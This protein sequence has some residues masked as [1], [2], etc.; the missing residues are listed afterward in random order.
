MVRYARALRLVVSGHTHQALEFG[1]DGVRHV[2]VPSSG[3]VI[4]DS[5]RVP[6]GDKVVGMGPLTLGAGRAHYERRMPS[7]MQLHEL[8]ALPFF[9]KPASG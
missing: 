1:A 8:T 5:M 7:G 6:V 9:A 4:N 3:F 2:W